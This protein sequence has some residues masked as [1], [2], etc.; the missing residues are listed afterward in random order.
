VLHTVDAG[1]WEWGWDALVA[2]GT[3]GL[4][5]VTLLL[6]VATL[7]T[8]R[9]AA[10]D[11]RANWRP[12]IVPDENLEIDWASNTRDLQLAIRNIGPGAA[13]NVEPALELA[14]G[15]LVVPGPR[16]VPRTD[17]LINYAVVASQ[18]TLDVFFEL[19]DEQPKRGRLIV[20]YSDLNGREYGS[21]ISIDTARAHPDDQERPILR[22]ASV[23]HTDNDK[24]AVP[25]E[26]PCNYGRRRTMRIALGRVRR[27]LRMR[28]PIEVGSRCPRN[29]ANT[30]ARKLGRRG[31]SDRPGPRRGRDRRR[32]R[33]S[34]RCCGTRRSGAA[35]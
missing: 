14:N 25:Y 5:L 16:F 6:A 1:P 3:I 32:T 29:H 9:A 34:R 22:I 31:C 4:A 27:A 12:L 35:R 13:Y 30:R 28:A 8:A 15:D 18:A 17:Q 21:T 2:I 10:Q 23:T 33:Y 11:V 7:Y 20:G 24:I 19:I 26:D